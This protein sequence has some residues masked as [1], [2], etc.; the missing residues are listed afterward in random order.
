M[1][2]SHSDVLYSLLAILQCLQYITAK[3]NI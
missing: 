1:P 2:V 3:H